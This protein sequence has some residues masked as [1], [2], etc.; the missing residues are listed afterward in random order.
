MELSTPL[1]CGAKNRLL[2]SKSG[3]EVQHLLEGGRSR[4]VAAS[5]L[6]FQCQIYHLRH[7][8]YRESPAVCSKQDFKTTVYY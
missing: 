7:Q 8:G 4:S 6:D 2:N 5:L 1:K 3:L